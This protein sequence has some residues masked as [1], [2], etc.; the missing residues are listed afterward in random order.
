MLLVQ[1]T[2]GSGDTF[3]CGSTVGGFTALTEL[4]EVGMEKESTQE[5]ERRIVF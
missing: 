1:A 5:G 4:T 2:S 3:N